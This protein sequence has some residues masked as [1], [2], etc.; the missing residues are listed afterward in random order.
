MFS[1]VHR[2]QTIIASLGRNVFALNLI[3]LALIATLA[4]LYIV[5]VNHATTK[6]YKIRDLET[7]IAR[8]K[9]ENKKMEIIATEARSMD[10]IARNVQMLG[11]VEA[12]APTYV[13]GTTPTF[14]L[15]R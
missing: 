3:L 14:T 15:N 4:L 11:M 5:Q 1:G 6:G 9:L 2:T 13:G 8:L 10:A 12:P 7:N